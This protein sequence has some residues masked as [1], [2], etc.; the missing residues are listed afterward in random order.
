MKADRRG[1]VELGKSCAAARKWN[2]NKLKVKGKKGS[3]AFL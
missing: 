2:S 1:A 3:L